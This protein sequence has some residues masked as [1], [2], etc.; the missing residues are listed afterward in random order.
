[1]TLIELVVV[2]AVL[3]SL[4]LGVTLAVGRGGQ[5]AESDLRAFQSAYDQARSL[6]I[7][8]QVRRGLL[9]EAK[10]RRSALWGAEGWQVSDQ[11]Q[12][13]RGQVSYLVDGPQARRDAPNILFLPNGQ[14]SAFRIQFDQIGCRSDG[15]TGLIC[16]AG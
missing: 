13:W 5:R 1:M 2:V 15:W 4:G 9:L 10:G 11:L 3:A 8:G 14:T 12:P 7:H 16:E 6:A